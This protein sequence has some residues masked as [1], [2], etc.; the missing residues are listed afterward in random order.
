MNNYPLVSSNMATEN[1]PNWM[2]EEIHWFLWSMASSTPCLMTPEGK[3][4]FI[5]IELW[6]NRFK[7]H[8]DPLNP[9]KSQETTTICGYLN[10]LETHWCWVYRNIQWMCPVHGR[11]AR[12]H[13][14][15]RCCCKTSPGYQPGPG[16][17]SSGRF[18]FAKKI[19]VTNLNGRKSYG[20]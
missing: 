4:P 1:P 7:T 13:P 6:L 18:L 14:A 15:P 20:I 17:R 19:W 8:S 2:E 5:P 3:H 11:C 9:F 10:H 12:D 16:P